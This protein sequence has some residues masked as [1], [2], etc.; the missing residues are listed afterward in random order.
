[1]AK[2]ADYQGQLHHTAEQLISTALELMETKP[3]DKVTVEE[4]LNRSGVARSSLYHHFEDFHHLMEVALIRKFTKDTYVAID[5]LIATAQGAETFDEARDMLHRVSSFIQDASRR[6]NRMLRAV[7]IA[8]SDRN[9]RF[10]AMLAV[11]QQKITD[12]Y[13]KVLGIGRERGWINPRVS[14]EFLSTLLQAYTVGRVIDDV[15]VNPLTN[16]EWISGI[17]ILQDMFFLNP[18]LTKG[19]E[20]PK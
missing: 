5:Q 6:E 1:M 13:A 17:A 7:A 16:E 10:R 19:L 8:T 14:P 9:D 4:V 3:V 12:G 18:E 11:E 20:P 2:K 15:A